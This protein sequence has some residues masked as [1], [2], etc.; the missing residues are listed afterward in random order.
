MKAIINIVLLFVGWGYL[1]PA[2]S[3]QAGW[4]RSVSIA[5]GTVIRIYAPQPDSLRGDILTFRSAFVL[6]PGGHQRNRD[7]LY[8]SIRA[9]AVISA[10]RNLR[11][12]TLRAVN[13]LSMQLSV[14]VNPDT[15]EGWKDALE[16][17]LPEAEKDIP[18]DELLTGDPKTFDAETHPALGHAPPRIITMPGPSVL[19]QIDG[20][21]QFR[22]HRE[23]DIGVAA[24]SPN[25]LI[26]GDNGWFYIYG[27][28]YWYIA[29]M[30]EGP[31][32]HTTEITQTM[33]FVKSVVDKDNERGAEHSDTLREGGGGL[34]E[35]V[36]SLV[37]AE[38]VQTRGTPLFSPIPGTGLVYV[39][40]SDN[41][42]FLDTAQHSYYLLL[43][44]RWYRSLRW[45]GGPWS[46]VAA[47][48]LPPDF[49]RIP[50]GSPKDNVLSS[51][52][53]TE[54]AREAL[55][56][57]CIP[58][59]ARIRRGATAEAVKYDVG[60]KFMPIRG[61][62]LQYA[63]NCPTPVFRER[64]NYY[65]VDRGVWFAGRGPSGPW[66]ASLT[67]PKEIDLIPADCPA[68]YCRFVYIYGYDNDYI[69]TGYTAGYLNAYIEKNT[70]VYG[71]GYTYAAW[72]GNDYYPRPQTWGFG[73]RYS[74]WF[75]WCLGY[76]A[77]LDWLNNSTA[78][79]FGYWSGGWWGPPAYRPP[80]IWHH[81]GGHGTYE[82]DMRRVENV[83]YNNDLYRV[84][85]P[86]ASLD[87]ALLCLDSAGRVC[88]Q[89]AGGGWERRN[90][91]QWEPVDSAQ[92]SG[93]NTQMKQ[94]RRS[95]MRVQ[96]FLQQRGVGAWTVLGKGDN[97]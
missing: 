65:C 39:V 20:I 42:I 9:L 71:T 45:L 16:Y 30:A 92:I 40:N 74:P 67:R 23:W 35:I 11:L 27:G 43:S 82:W 86:V 72:K 53:G 21:P 33:Q 36:I 83:N 34:K 78:W 56:D 49:A 75:G 51:V 38:L 80:Y 4:P 17:G 97:L 87:A 32:H 10:D 50:E 58:Q 70:V 68:Y 66:I 31:Y 5:D 69:Y 8:G 44:G 90:G 1:M 28:R 94:M 59:T 18:L 91:S 15:L 84:F 61:T 79:G 64:E 47:D 7:S 89:Q 24:N 46:Y 57:A 22:R 88:R 13:L 95:R 2:A 14:S 48:S 29:P 60:P 63:I 19:V 3:A 37:P 54:A 93:L 81:F 62:Q 6:I 76:D 25:T 85:R 26:E 12:V 55:L 41:D 73:M 96:N 52:A 77:G